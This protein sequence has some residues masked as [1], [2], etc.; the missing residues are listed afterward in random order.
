MPY[1]VSTKNNRFLPS[2]DMPGRLGKG[3]FLSK[4]VNSIENQNRHS[5]GIQKD[6]QIVF[7]SR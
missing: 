4:N 5:M 3:N 6:D 2:V 7:F 1:G